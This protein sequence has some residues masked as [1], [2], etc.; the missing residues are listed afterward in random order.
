MKVRILSALISLCFT[1]QAQAVPAAD[2]VFSAADAAVFSA[3]D[4]AKVQT[5]SPQDQEKLR[6]AV[7]EA[8]G[9]GVSPQAVWIMS[10]PFFRGT[11][12]DW[13]LTWATNCGDPAATVACKLRGF[14]RALPGAYGTIAAPPTYVLGTDQICNF[15]GCTGFTWVGCEFP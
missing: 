6:K 1:W 7:A 3:T 5:L 12:I 4:D 11:R 2:T 15:P 10:L 13:C 14:R 9:Q 8:Q